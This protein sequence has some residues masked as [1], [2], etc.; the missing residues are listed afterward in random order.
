MQA[1][2]LNEKI[3]VER[4]T[5]SQT[6]SGF[7]RSDEWQTV[8]ETRAEVKYQSGGRTDDNG[9]LFFARDILF[10]VRFYHDIRNLDRIVWKDKKYRILEI[11]EQRE[12]QRKIIRTELINE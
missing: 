5:N 11:E 4:Q 10:M 3:S 1:G 6:S 12:I 2:R 8:I 9:E 7:M